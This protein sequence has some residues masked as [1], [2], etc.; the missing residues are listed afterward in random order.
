MR[1][2]ARAASGST[3][4][5]KATPSPLPEIRSPRNRIPQ[6]AQRKRTLLA[7]G[8]RV[9]AA[10]DGSELILVAPMRVPYDVRRWFEIWLNEFRAE[11]I[12]VIQADAGGRT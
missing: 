10:P 9:G 2:P 4:F 1:T 6:P 11:V 7:L 3:A 12:A 5:P 8:I